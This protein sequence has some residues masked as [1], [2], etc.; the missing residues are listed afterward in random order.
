MLGF[1]RS[2]TK[3]RIGV[4]FALVF[5]GLIALSFAGAD[6]SGAKFG[7]GGGNADRAVTVGST[8]IGTIEV[9]KAMSNALENARADSPTVTMK[10]FVAQGAL[11]QVVDSLID[12]AALMEWARLS[13]VGMGVSSRLVDSEIAKMS[14]F[15][16]ADGKFSQAAYKALLGQKGISDA[17]LRDD[18]AKGLM[19][20]QVLIPAGIGSTMPQS[21]VLRY[22]A[23][24]KETR[25]GVVQL[26]PSSAFA[27]KTPP[28]DADLAAFYKANGARYQRP[29]RRTI[30]YAI[31]D[32]TSLRNVPAPSDA[33]IAARYKLNA[34]TYAPTETRTFT[35]VIVP[36]EAA[37]KALSAEIA[38]GKSIDAAAAAKGLTARKIAAITR[39][40]LVSQDSTAVADAVFGAAQGKLAQPAKG[41]LGWYVIRLD[42]VTAVP[43]KSLDQARAE[44]VTAISAEKRKIALADLSAKFDDAFGSG[45]GLADVAKSAG[46]TVITTD[47]LEANGTVP[48][49]PDIKPNADVTPLLQAAFG[50]EREG[51]PQVAELKAGERY[52][53]FDIGQITP[54]APPPLAE[55]KDKVAADLQTSRGYGAAKA[56]T[57]KVMAA[58][59]R[60]VPL[61]EAL[62][63]LGVALPPA[64]SVN[65]PREQLNAM[66]PKIPATLQLMFEMAQG[67]AKK[68]E[69]PDKAG[70]LVV[71]LNK[72]TP[73]AVKADDPFVA[74]ARVE[75]G[76]LAGREYVDELRMAVREAVG[77]KRNEPAITALRTQLNGG[78]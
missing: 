30:R 13:S 63:T 52:V 5:L 78:Q 10:D 59:A 57:D 56:A 6:I 55:V 49:R 66:Q 19:A 48:G 43:G 53:I 58:L 67:T 25:E 12:R 34:A 54:A 35:Q 61:A 36:T 47:P 51:Q 23:V 41:A 64:Q 38:G 76:Q 69:A 77:V 3:S 14:A 45:T 32:E 16:G 37:A 7:G 28:T 33:E 71:V 39:A 17:L 8:H 4:A 46:L 65:I 20:R 26:V 68:L 60:K 15:Q 27:P 9:Q 72:V 31:F 24:L 50:M 18:V 75:L 1:I 44:I 74:R 2:L 42:G 40:N 29:E 21:V 62:K 11:E 73:G 22:A 70:F